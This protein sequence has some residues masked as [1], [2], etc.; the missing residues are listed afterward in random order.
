MKLIFVYN[1]KSDKINAAIGFA[2][3][4]I[5]PSTYSCSLCMLTHSSYGE[6]KEWKTFLDTIEADIEFYHSDEFEKNYTSIN[7]EYP[8]VLRK[9]GKELEIIFDNQRLST[10]KDIDEMIVELEKLR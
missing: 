3:K 7:I 10:F 6:R 2:H 9:A 4:I 5:S 8:V 1:A